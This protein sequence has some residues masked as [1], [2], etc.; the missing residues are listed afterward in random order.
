MIGTSVPV[1]ET[2]GTASFSLLESDLHFPHPGAG[3]TPN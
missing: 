3:I 1:P 2:Q